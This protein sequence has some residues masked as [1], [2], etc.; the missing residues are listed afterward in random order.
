MRKYQRLQQ[1][2]IDHRKHGRVHPDPHRDHQNR[3]DGEPW[4]LRKRPHHKLQVPPQALHPGQRAIPPLGVAHCVPPAKLHAR[5]P[6]RLVR[7]HAARPAQVFVMRQVRLNLF[8]QLRV[9]RLASK[10]PPQIHKPLP[11]LPIT[12]LIHPVC[13]HP[14]LCSSR[15]SPIA[16]VILRH[17]LVSAASFRFPAGVN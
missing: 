14:G 10:K 15:T 2:S 1:H 16:R 6:P 5:L 7:I 12:L 4:R 8:R 3:D 17:L 9:L 13:V 11:L